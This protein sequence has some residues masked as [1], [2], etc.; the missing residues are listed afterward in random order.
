MTWKYIGTENIKYTAE[1]I[2]NWLTNGFSWFMTFV[3]G[4]LMFTKY[5][6][7]LINWKILYILGILCISVILLWT[8]H[9]W[10]F[11]NIFTVFLIM[12]TFLYFYAYL[13]KKNAFN[14]FRAKDKKD[15]YH[16]NTNE[17]I[18]NSTKNKLE[19][20]NNYNWL[21]P[22]KKIKKHYESFKE[23]IENFSIKWNYIEPLKDDPIN[24]WEDIF[25]YNSLSKNIYDL[26]NWINTKRIKSSYSIWIVWEWW[27][28][29]SSV[30]NL[31]EQEHIE[32]NYNFLLYKFNPWNYEK[33]ELVER[34]FIDLGKLLW[35][36]EFTKLTYRYLDLIWWLHDKFKIVTNILKLIFWEKTL[37]NIKDD[38]WNYLSEVDKKIIIVID[39]LD[40]CEPEEVIITLNLIKN[41][42]NFQNIIYLVS[43]DKLHVIKILE[44]KWFDKDYL[45]KIIN[46][47]KFI[48]NPSEDKLKEYFKFQLEQILGNIEISEDVI[49]DWISKIFSNYYG[50]F[51]NENMRFI[52]KLLNQLNIILQMNKTIANEYV[53][54][55]DGQSIL[56]IFLI[57]YIKLKDINFY[58]EV[59]NNKDFIKRWDNKIIYN[60]NNSPEYL[61][62]IKE[63]YLYESFL[64]FNWI[65]IKEINDYEVYWERP[66]FSV[67]DSQIHKELIKFF[68]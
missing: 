68:W 16:F 2:F 62:N 46:I 5:N 13:I 27:L 38:I 30:L 54:V 34:F 41:L 23:K 53:Q 17:K 19:L 15:S 21:P 66:W 61:K 1:I 4:I 37:E 26:L 22:I 6:F 51:M 20:D 35:K 31:L 14:I 59:L 64:S 57:N 50:F 29:K 33:K 55:L 43:Y 40:R 18:F 25:W 39:D 12:L 9:S 44:E 28:W 49:N 48:K 45:D 52:K 32:W 58:N 10:I 65:A 56:Y 60:S 24:T 42:W 7:K 67:V 8:K 47:E 11:M 3:L 63:K 36:T